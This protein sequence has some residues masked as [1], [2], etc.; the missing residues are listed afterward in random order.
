LLII[1]FFALPA[2]FGIIWAV[3]LTK[4]VISPE[5]VSDI[6]RQVIDEAPVLLEEI[7]EDAQD[8]DFV[9]DGNTRTW[10]RTAAEVGVSPRRLMEET[11]LD[12]WMENELSRTLQEAG[13][14]LRGRRRMR[15]LTI[16]L[17][18]LKAALRHEAIDRALEDIFRALPP[19][20]YREMEEW[21]DAFDHDVDWFMLPPCRPDADIALSIFR[22][23]RLRALE[24]MDD[25]IEIFEGVRSPAIGISRLVTLVS[26]AIFLI[27]VLFLFAGA[28]I[29]GTSPA[30]FFRWFGI[31]TLIGG[32]SALVLSFFM[33]QLV[34]WGLQFSPQSLWES[35]MSDL[36]ELIVEK[37][38]WIPQLVVGRLFSDV[39]A[40]AG[41]V[42]VIGLVIFAVSFIVRGERRVRT[43][44]TASPARPIAPKTPD[45]QVGTKD[46]KAEGSSEG[47]G[48]LD[49][50]GVEKEK[51]PLPEPDEKEQ[52]E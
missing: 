24:D 39:I 36:E 15:T 20:D 52:E 45:A 30:G 46:K 42:C 35:G 13:D 44:P 47:V 27:P 8:P 40:L 16:D 4:A 6:P 51:V 14:I 43:R 1:L 48:S 5:F 21:E 7:F 28:I 32:F 22:A 38:A 18:P 33:K 29:A 50:E 37:V 11:G 3:G 2:L 19:C 17:V 23:E 25:E 26:Y 34:F 9:R 10:F 49:E 41:V 12:D 31:S